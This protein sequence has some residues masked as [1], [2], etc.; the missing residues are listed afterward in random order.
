MSRLLELLGGLFAG[1]AG[2][3]LLS[4]SAGALAPA[5]SP[6]PSPAP[7]APPAPPALVAAPPEAPASAAPE[8]A[9]YELEARL[10]A[11]THVITGK[12]TLRWTNTSDKPVTELFFHLYL[13]AF[14]NERT[15]FLRSPFGAG[16]SG[17][18]GTRYG[19]IDV[20]RLSAR[21]LG[22]RD[23][24]PG[25]ARSSPGDAEDETD[26]RVPLPEP[27]AP[28]RTLHL[29][30]EWSSQLPEIVERTGYVQGFH[31]VAQWY[32]KIAR[33]EPD[34][35]WAHFAFHP[36]SEFYADFGRYAVTLDVPA[37]LRVGATG[38]LVREEP[39]GDRKKLRYEA[40]AV[41]DFAWS[42]WEHFREKRESIDGVDVRLLHPPGHERNAHRSLEV[43]RHALPRFSAAYGRY[44]HP[45][46]TVVH[47]PDWARNA[48]GMEY[49]T[50]ITT[51]GPWWL[52]AS[53]IRG[54]EAVTVHELGHQWFQGVIATDESRWPFL[55][56]G[57]NTHAEVRVMRELYGPGSMVDLL[58]LELSDEALRRV[59][60][61]DVGQTDA[62]AQPAAA[63][64]SFSRLGAVVYGRTATLLETLGAVYGQAQLE[65]ALG[66]YARRGRF[67]HPEP[68]ELE[69]AVREAMG[70][71]AADALHVGLFEKGWV[72]YS[73]DGLECV[74]SEADGEETSRCRVVVRRA[75]NLRLPV[76]VE[77]HLADGSRKRSRWSGT[78][79]WKA[80]E[81]SGK[82]RVVAAV[83]DPELRVSLDHHL[84][85]NGRRERGGFA[86]RT[87]ERTTYALELLLWGFGP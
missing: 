78:E 69:D 27:I 30:L 66:L 43:L 80:F 17:E 26:I 83:V 84:G 4:R 45:T 81:H 41:H 56:E 61:I 29:E 76:D 38:K 10:D 40:E 53:G 74:P 48:G 13:N 54:V 44:P 31:L 42:A 73:V 7:P 5:L 8:V 1:A 37:A 85:N 59:E 50:L 47:P 24:W 77:L 11:A 21:E 58:G 55:D 63:F 71:E 32:P 6:A 22:G 3:L 68:R 23:L 79:S 65:R 46:L 75:G 14:K 19:H 36:Q 34:G 16:R 20:S 67:R 87:L 64:S 28:G 82:E 70:G 86:H 52:A 18:H 72:D 25:A 39:A 15:L 2:L 12:G 9:S 51:G 49:P 60:A 57:V 35:R 33:L 62:I